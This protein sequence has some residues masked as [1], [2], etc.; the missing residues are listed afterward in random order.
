MKSCLLICTL[1]VACGTERNPLYEAET[2]PVEEVWV[3]Y[4]PDSAEHN[5]ICTEECFESGNRHTYCWLLEEED[6][7]INLRHEW[8]RE[9]CPLLGK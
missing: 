2:P 9:C 1:L 3:C 6:C 8:Q 7:K 5:K 4:N